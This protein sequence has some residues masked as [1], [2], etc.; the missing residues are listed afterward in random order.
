MM[1]WIRA[2][3]PITI[4]LA[5][6]VALHLCVVFPALGLLGEGRGQGQAAEATQPVRR[7]RLDG[8]SERGDRSDK[9]HAAERAAENSR[10]ALQERRE[11]ERSR[12]EELRE[13]EDE[14][15]LGIDNSNAVTM[16]W[17][18]YDE[19]QQHLA[20]LAEVEQAAMRLQAASGSRGSA[21]ARPSS[22]L[23]SLRCGSTTR[24]CR[25]A[26]CRR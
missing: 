2:N 8:S 19:Y 20:E 14:V 24:R 12:P 6:S 23:S 15:R 21:T 22:R 7:D 26:S 10:R 11:R 5:L 17:I 1:Q 16:N 18:G 3:L 25:F 13:R 4:A 9:A